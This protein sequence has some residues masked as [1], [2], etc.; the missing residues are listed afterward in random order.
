MRIVRLRTWPVES[1]CLFAAF[2]VVVLY[3][4]DAYGIHRGQGPAIAWFK[5]PAGNIL[6]VLE[7][8]GAAS[9]E[10]KRLPAPPPRS[11]C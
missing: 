8:L 1:Y 7:G 11:G 6:S 2:L 5:D 3:E 9:L 4:Q 10:A